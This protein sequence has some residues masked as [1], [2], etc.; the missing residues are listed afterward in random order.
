MVLKKII[1]NPNR[2]LISSPKFN[3]INF[4][5]ILFIVLMF[6][7]TKTSLNADNLDLNSLCKEVNE[8][9]YSFDAAKIRDLIKVSD[10]YIESNPKVYY[11]YYFNGILRY[12][13]GR[14]TFNI[15]GDSAYDYFDTS[16]DMFE[17]AWEI[18][19]SPESLAM[20]SAAYGK[21]SALSPL[22]AIF[23]GQ[24]AKNRIYDA[25]ILD[26]N[27]TKVI[28]VAATHLMHVPG[29]YGG[30]KK[31][32]RQMLEKCLI[33]NKKKK[34]N[35]QYELTWADDAEIYA[36]LAQIDILE[37]K[38]E[39]ARLNMKKS[40]NLKPNYGFVLVDLENQIKEA[41]K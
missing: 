33:L 4:A 24:K 39:S 8:A 16:L 26:S 36:Y 37:E 27:N 18:N 23:F 5:K 32:S 2:R 10:K 40:L 1:F 13:L 34:D 6:C 41:T 38:F 31:K 7:C 9:Y 35:K 21:K 12:C 15:D 30:D 3:A 11:G 28:L 20:I 14:I 17:K 29:I 19:K 22:R 25:Y